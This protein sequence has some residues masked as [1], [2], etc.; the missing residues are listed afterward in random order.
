MNPKEIRL[1]ASHRQ[2]YVQDSEPP[3]STDDPAFWTD[4]TSA[5][6]LAITDGILGIR[7]GSYDD[8]TVRAEGFSS[9]PAL[10]LSQWDHVTEAG[11]EVRTGLHTGECELIGN[12]LGG[13]AVHIGARVANEANAAE[14]LVSSTNRGTT[15]LSSSSR[16]S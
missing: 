13:L 11:L 4:K 8:V 10:D 15:F 2:F 3:G 1:Y 6:R 16:D 5:D 12:D 7:T 9:E 14:V